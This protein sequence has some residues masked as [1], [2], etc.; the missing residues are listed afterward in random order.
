MSRVIWHDVECGNYDED[1]ALWRDLATDPAHAPGPILDVGAGTGRVALDLARRGHEVVALDHDAALL[2]ALELRAGGLPVS[3]R[4]ADARDFDLGRRFGLILAPMQTV[5][6][7]GSDGRAGF[8][9]SARR[10]LKLG[11]LLAV[12]LADALEAFDAEHC[13][14]PAPDV[15]RVAGVLY[16]SRPVALREEGHRVAI[17]R[18]RETV[19]P[20]G[21]RTADGD[22]VHLDRLDVTDLEREAVAAGLRPRVARRIAQT[23]EHVGSSVAMLGG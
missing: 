22:V 10:H 6:L 16:A 23:G 7:L 13:E 4:V 18:I 3:T 20:D 21:T 17:E 8:L 14:A 19:A 15:R 11:G 1:L 9:A 2:D 12:A 5:Q